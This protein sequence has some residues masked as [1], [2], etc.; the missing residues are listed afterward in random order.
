MP[1]KKGSGTAQ[2]KGSGT[3]NRNGPKVALHFR[4]LP[5]FSG[6]FFAALISMALCGLGCDRYPMVRVYEAPKDPPPKRP[7][8]MAQTQGPTR[9][10]I[11]VVPAGEKVFFLKASDRPDRLDGFD[12][13]L[14]QIAAKLKTSATDIDWGLPDGWTKESSSGIVS[15]ILTAPESMGSVRVTVTELPGPNDGNWDSYLEANINR[16]RGQ[17]RLPSNTFAEQKPTLVEVARGE[18]QPSAWIVDLQSEDSQLAST[19]TPPTSPPSP[20]SGVSAQKSSPF[21]FSAPNGWTDEGP[22]G[23]RAAS[24]VLKEADQSGEVSV[25]VASGDIPS[26]VT[27]WQGQVTPG[28]TPEEIE[29]RAKKAIDEASKIK[30]ANGVEGAIYTLLADDSDDSASATVAA[31]L[32]YGEGQSSVFVKMIGPKKLLVAH[33]ER[34]TKFIETLSW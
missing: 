16:W 2:K 9:F 10:V 18:G 6:S 27:R 24:F 4:Y 7:P 11:G 17:L 19:E 3:E 21:T 15:T 14:R 1:P 31:I 22:K 25:I 30:A 29:T 12:A 13:P 33:R 5:P 23:M 26:N 32:P 20:N 28:A 34:F 8:N